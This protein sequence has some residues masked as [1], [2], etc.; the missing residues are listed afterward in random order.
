MVKDTFPTYV[1]DGELLDGEDKYYKL[2]IK[3]FELE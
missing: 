1:S 3:I 2:N